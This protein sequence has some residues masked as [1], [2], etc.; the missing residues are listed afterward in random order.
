M[1]GMDARGRGITP[2]PPEVAA[3]E[4]ALEEIEGRGP[5]VKEVA[6]TVFFDRGMG[7]T[8]TP[9]ALGVSGKT[10]LQVANQGNLPKP[11]LEACF[12]TK[13]K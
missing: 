5:K 6:A 1:D 12:K 2:A 9:K 11:S 4:V 13:K 7:I 10:A 3:V 8:M